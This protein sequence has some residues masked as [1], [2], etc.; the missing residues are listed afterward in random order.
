[1]AASYNKVI[2]LGNVTRDPD[3]R[4]T[5]SGTSVLDLGLAITDKRKNGNEWIETTVY[6]D[7]TLWGKMAEIAAEYIN[8]GDSVLIEGRLQMDSWE[9]D[10]KKRSKL[11]LVGDR[12]QMLGKKGGQNAPNLDTVDTPSEKPSAPSN[13]LASI[14]GPEDDI[15]F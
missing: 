9:Q 3:M 5:K 2:V 10:G 1:M 7:T 12:M 14:D 4:F 8:K 13:P 6:V 15:P 11:K